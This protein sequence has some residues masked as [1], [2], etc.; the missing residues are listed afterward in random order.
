MKMLKRFFAMVLVVACVFCF[1]V[2]A[3]ASVW[4]F[5]TGGQ[6]AN[7]FAPR[8]YSI[9]YKDSDNTYYHEWL[10]SSYA[11]DGLSGKQRSAYLGTETDEIASLDTD[12]YEIV[13]IYAW[14]DKNPK[15]YAFSGNSNSYKD[16]LVYSTTGGTPS[17]KLSTVT[18]V[19]IHDRL[20]IRL[21]GH[22]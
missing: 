11:H 8:G 18:G 19:T 13:A 5:G 6:G 1:S 12:D 17:T 16:A 22:Q 21:A 3:L 4:T 7:A 15:G 10:D 9:V 14:F 20:L 2:N